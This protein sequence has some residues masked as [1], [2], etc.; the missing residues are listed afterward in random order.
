MFGISFRD[1]IG[2]NINSNL[3]PFCTISLQWLDCLYYSRMGAASMD[4]K[5]LAQRID[6]TTGGLD[7]DTHVISH[8]TEENTFEQVE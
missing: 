1:I 4:Y 5:E 2:V 6:L 7:A 3:G 8:H